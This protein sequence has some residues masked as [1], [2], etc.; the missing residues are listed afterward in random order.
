[1]TTAAEK[2][3]SVSSLP[4]GNTAGDHLLSVTKVAG[5]SGIVLI[6][7]NT[8]QLELNTIVSA[9]SMNSSVLEIEEMTTIQ[10]NNQNILEL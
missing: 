5:D 4:T 10:A 3:L 7:N 8:N 9:I 6:A 2:L 1:M